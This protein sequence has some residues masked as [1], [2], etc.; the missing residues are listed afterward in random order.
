MSNTLNKSVFFFPFYKNEQLSSLYKP[1][2]AFRAAHKLYQTKFGINPLLNPNS[3]G[4]NC[5]NPLPTNRIEQSK[6][7]ILAPNVVI[8]YCSSDG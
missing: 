8:E 6:V 5:L 4:E 3:L 7:S 1:T 2:N